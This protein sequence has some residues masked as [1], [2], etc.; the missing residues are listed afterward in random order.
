M[1]TPVL[2][3]RPDTGISF[4]NRRYCAT[5]RE[6]EDIE[7]DRIL[8]E[9]IPSPSHNRI[10]NTIAALTPE[11]PSAAIEFPVTDTQGRNGR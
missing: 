9:F 3:L 7:Y 6:G 1:A 5:F 8:L 2:R 4:T 11:A 10:L